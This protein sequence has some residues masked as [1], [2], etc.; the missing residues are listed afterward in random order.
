LYPDATDYSW[1]VS[2]L[3]W[4]QPEE[5]PEQDP[6]GLDTHERLVEVYEDGDVE[7]TIMV[8]DEVLLTVI[9]SLFLIVNFG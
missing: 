9:K 1:V 8:D 3:L 4:I 7:D 5:L 2:T 6:A